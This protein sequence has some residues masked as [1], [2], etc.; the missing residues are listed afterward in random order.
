MIDG[1]LEGAE[2]LRALTNSGQRL[3]GTFGKFGGFRESVTFLGVIGGTQQPRDR[4]RFVPSR[5]P[6][7]GTSGGIA[8]AF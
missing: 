8:V 7:S 5:Q 2:G 6:V 1:S 3:T 4:L